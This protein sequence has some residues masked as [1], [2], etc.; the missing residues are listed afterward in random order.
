MV[1]RSK[2]YCC[3]QLRSRSLCFSTTTIGLEMGV[4][5]GWCAT[6]QVILVGSLLGRSSLD[7]PVQRAQPQRPTPSQTAVP[8]VAVPQHS[9]RNI[10]L[11]SGQVLELGGRLGSSV[12]YV[13]RT[14]LAEATHNSCQAALR[15]CCNRLGFVDV[16]HPAEHS[17]RLAA[18]LESVRAQSRGLVKAKHAIHATSRF[19]FNNSARQEEV[20]TTWPR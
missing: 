7:R 3:R 14:E 13:L 8:Q 19:T 17:A 2:P 20:L 5:A 6:H 10:Q 18:E 16:E 4:P 11:R 12:L 9:C 1:Q 15:H